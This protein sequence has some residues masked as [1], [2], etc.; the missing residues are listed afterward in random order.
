MIA[1]GLAGDWGDSLSVLV[2]ILNG[3]VT[4]SIPS[5]LFD[6]PFSIFAFIAFTLWLRLQRTGFLHSRTRSRL[7]TVFAVSAVFAVVFF[8]VVLFGG[9]WDNGKTAKTAK[10]AQRGTP[11]GDPAARRSSPTASPFW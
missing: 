1:K 11:K 8:L 4:G 7:S 3:L 6:C 2:L 9:F 10:T 5:R